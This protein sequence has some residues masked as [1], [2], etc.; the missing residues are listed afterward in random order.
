VL[1]HDF[2]PNGAKI[3]K[4]YQRGFAFMVSILGQKK[5]SNTQQGDYPKIAY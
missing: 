5:L 4:R 1:L 2:G 3:T